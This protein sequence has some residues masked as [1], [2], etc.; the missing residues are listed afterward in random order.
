MKRGVDYLKELG[1]GEGNKPRVL[2]VEDNDE[3]R[4]AYK[5]SLEW[6]GFEVVAVD[7][8]LKFVK[9]LKDQKALGK[10]FHVV[11]SDTDMPEMFGDEACKKALEKRLLD[12][13][14][15]VLAMSDDIHN[16]YY[17][18]G[19]AHHTGFYDKNRVS[20]M[21][22]QVMSHYYNFVKGESSMWRMR[23]F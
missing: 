22:S 17:W 11:L 20:D 5:H 18:N 12:D 19:I 7:D 2:L 3:L 1:F 9:T 10:R 6:A 15:L 4:V 13:N 8:G 14:V 21:G 16:D 23:M